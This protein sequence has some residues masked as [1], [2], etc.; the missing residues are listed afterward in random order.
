MDIQCTELSHFLSSCRFLAL[1]LAN[2]TRNKFE[3]S[4]NS[5]TK[6]SVLKSS[7]AYVVHSSTNKHSI[8]SP[9]NQIVPKN[10]RL[11]WTEKKLKTKISWSQNLYLNSY[12][13]NIMILGLHDLTVKMFTN[14]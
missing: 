13:G 10:A 6:I 4:E 3:L 5:H 8:Q 1:C 11:T 2:N 12:R 7:L 14:S 9:K